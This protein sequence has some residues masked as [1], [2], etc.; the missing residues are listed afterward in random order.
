MTATSPVRGKYAPLYRFL[1][2]SGR[3]D[4]EVTFGKIADLVDGG[5]PPSAYDHALPWWSNAPRARHVQAAAWLAAGY[6][7]SSVDNG[8][9]TVRFSRSVEHAS[10]S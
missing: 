7:V 5:L 3:E 2:D 8:Q 6:E 9:C 1:R 4:L 10:R